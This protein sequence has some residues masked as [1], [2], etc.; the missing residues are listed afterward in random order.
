[1]NDPQFDVGNKPDEAAL[2]PY[3]A[4]YPQEP[5]AKKQHGCFF[6]G[7]IIAIV[8]LVLGL[9]LFGALAYMGYYYY[10]KMLQE[11]TA[12]APVEI[13]T[14]TLSSDEQKA[15]DDRVAAFKKAL[16][17]GQNAELVL[18]ADDINAL[19]AE[20]PDLKG[21]VYVSLNGDEISAKVSVPLDK[22]PFPGTKGRYFN[23][24]G[25]FKASVEDGDL[26][27][28]AVDLEANGKKLPPEIK[29]QLAKENLAKNFNADPDTYK[30]IRKF[31]SI[32]IKDGKVHIKARAKPK[33]TEEETDKAKAEEPGKDEEKA[34]AKDETKD[35]DK[36][37]AAPREPEKKEEAT[38]KDEPKKAA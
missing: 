37:K 34:K 27:V 3:E 13:Q 33:E 35:E 6:Y 18:T 1:M 11:W 38:P 23:G 30:Y 17:D 31:E 25:T 14:V 5:P 28:Y 4:G 24:S 10:S 32:K 16:D 21:R 29:A 9:I 2:T 22:T 36:E 19:I 15:L 26:V 12:T 8:L 20:H 7:C